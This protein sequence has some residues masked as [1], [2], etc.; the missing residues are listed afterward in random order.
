MVKWM[1]IGGIAVVMFLGV[2]CFLGCCLFSSLGEFLDQCD[3]NN[4]RLRVVLFFC[5]L[6]SAKCEGVQRTFEIDRNNSDCYNNKD[7][8]IKN[9]QGKKAKDNEKQAI[10]DVS[11][12][13]INYEFINWLW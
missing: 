6:K 13:S 8:T 2:V 7:C 11:N 4:S 12:V 3:K 10:I 5:E 1:I 9:R